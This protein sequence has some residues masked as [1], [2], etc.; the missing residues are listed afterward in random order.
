MMQQYQPGLQRR[1]DEL[2][3]EVKVDT[4]GE[5]D[6][7]Q[8]YATN[9]ISYGDSRNRVAADTVDTFI[10][11]DDADMLVSFTYNNNLQRGENET[12]E[13]YN[14]RVAEATKKTSDLIEKYGNASDDMA[15]KLASIIT[16]GHEIEIRLQS[17]YNTQQK[18]LAL[19][20]VN[21]DNLEN[22]E[23]RNRR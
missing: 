4:N 3:Q 21:A 12:D 18:S 7:E 20:G 19:Y 9:A 23:R 11:A 2:V 1:Y 22:V 16:L 15:Q 17:I 13:E 5:L 6:I 14:A 8:L 10:G